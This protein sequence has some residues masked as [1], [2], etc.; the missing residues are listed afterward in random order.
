M[1]GKQLGIA[2][3]TVTREQKERTDTGKSEDRE[4]TREA[5][6]KS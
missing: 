6:G 3:T 2:I 4:S 1:S 5:S